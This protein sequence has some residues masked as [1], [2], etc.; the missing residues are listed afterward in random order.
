MPAQRREWAVMDTFDGFSLE[1]DN[2]QRVED[3]AR[4]FSL[5]SC[6]VTFAGV[7]HYPA[8]CSTVVRAIKLAT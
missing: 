4:M 5:R 1:F 2:P 6:E 8:G 7:A 3:V